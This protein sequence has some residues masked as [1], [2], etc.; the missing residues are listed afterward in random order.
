MSDSKYGR[1]ASSFLLVTACG[2]FFFWN[3]IMWEEFL[4]H[5]V[6]LTLLGQTWD[7][8]WPFQNKC[9]ESLPQFDISSETHWC[10]PA[11][12]M[13]TWLLLWDTLKNKAY[14]NNTCTKNYLKKN[15]GYSVFFFTSS[16]FTWIKN[17]CYMWCVFPSQ[18][19]PFPACS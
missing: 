9:T 7:A 8:R 14:S 3:L 16:S 19:K 5:M 2:H 17:V 6:C 15:S 10:H 13:T 1:G 11:I 18:R 4:V 12:R